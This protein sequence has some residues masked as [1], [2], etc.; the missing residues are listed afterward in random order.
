VLPMM[1]AILSA[2]MILVLLSGA[3]TVEL[4]MDEAGSSTQV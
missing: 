4:M 2:F 1:M 3:V